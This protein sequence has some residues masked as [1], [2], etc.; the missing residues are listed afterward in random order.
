MK[1]K[2]GLKGSFFADQ[3]HDFWS[4]FDVQETKDQTCEGCYFKGFKDCP[5]HA[6]LTVCDHEIVVEKRKIKK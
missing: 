3:L 2:R 6:G 5:L 4:K 1:L